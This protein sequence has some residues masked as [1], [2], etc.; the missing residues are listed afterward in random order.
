MK[1]L[2]LS[3][4]VFC[5]APSLAHSTPVAT[6]PANTY[7]PA[8]RALARLVSGNNRYAA[9]QN[10]PAKPLAKRR[11]EL[12]Q[13]QHPFAIIVGCSDSRV[14]PEMVFDQTLGDLFVVRSAGNLVDNIGL[15]SLEYAVD[16]LGAR[17]IVVLAHEKCGAI[18]AALAKG[19]AHGH[20]QDIVDAIGPIGGDVGEQ[21]G[22][23]MKLA[24]E[25]NAQHVKAHILK[26]SSIIRNKVH[27]GDVK[28]VTA[29]YHLE[30]GQVTFFDSY[31]P[32]QATSPKVPAIGGQHVDSKK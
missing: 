1:N 18:A 2:W 5:L 29:Y 14:P 12:L 8:D 28:I 21:R 31:H 13:G 7:V 23:Y 11:A 15:G 22:D 20:I 3:L 30:S 25:K 6:A 32:S 10:S 17:L 4:L 27:S 16:H 19:D 26:E 9:T 24:A